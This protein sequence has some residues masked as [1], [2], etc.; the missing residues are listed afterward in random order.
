MTA[1]A[2]ELLVPGDITLDAT[3]SPRGRFAS[4][5]PL[6]DG[7]DRL[8]VTWSQCRLLDPASP[9]PLNPT[10]VPCTPALLAMPGI[11]EAPPL[12]GVWMFDVAD[13]TQQPL[14][15]PQEGFAYTE[16]VVMEARTPPAVRL[17]KVAG[18]DF[19]PDLV[20]GE[21][22]RTAHPQRLRLRRHCD[23]ADRRVARSG[24]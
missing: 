1:D 20:S 18:L 23:G 8:L 2:Q 11:Q 13:G 16:A 24:G 12:Y 14:V 7:T 10:I 4:V 21:R 3:P 5:A 9:D 19:D 15:T 6:F 17:D 22:R